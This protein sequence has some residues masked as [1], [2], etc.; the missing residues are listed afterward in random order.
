MSN[1][2]TENFLKAW[3]EW[4]SAPVELKSPE[5]RLYYDENGCPLVYSME[6]LP[7]NYILLDQ[8]TWRR[9]SPHVKVID[10]RLVELSNKYVTRLKPGDQGTPCHPTNVSVVVDTTEPNQKWRMT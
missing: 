6:D 1:E 4:V 3:R 8:A 5:Y 10:G 2:T 7:G 9:T